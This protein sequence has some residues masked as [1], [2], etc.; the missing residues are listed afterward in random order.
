M[1][2]GISWQ[3]N[4]FFLRQVRPEILSC[5]RPHQPVPVEHLCGVLQQS[6]SAVDLSDT[7]TGKTY[8][9][10]ATAIQL[11]LPTL[12]VCPKI[13][14]Y[15]WSAAATHFNDSFSIINYE[16]LRTGRTPFGYW[17][18]ARDTGISQRETYYVC[19]CCQ[20]EVDVSNWTACPHHPNGVHC[21]VEKKRSKNLGNFV[22][23]S[24]IKCAIFDEAHRC[25]GLD[26]LNAE[27][28]IAARRQ[29]IRTL[30]LSATAACN[31]LNMRAIGY[32]LDL[33]NDKHDFI[34]P[35]GKLQ[36][37][38]R[39]SFKRWAAGYGCRYEPMFRGMK[40]MVGAAT[41]NQMM[42]QIRDRIIPARGVRVRV[43]DIPDFPKRTITAELYDLDESNHIDELYNEM[44]DSLA[45]LNQKSKTDKSATHPLTKLLR[46]RQRLELLKV[47]IAVELAEDYL[48]TGHSV[49]LFVNFRQ[50]L[51]ELQQRLDCDCIIAGDQSAEHRAK[52]IEFFQ[53][54]RARVIIIMVQAGGVSLSL[55]DL[56]G[57]Y[58]RVGLV[59]PDFSAPN[60]RQV[61]GRLHRDGGRSPCFYRVLFVAR[62]V[63]TQIHR[64][65]SA[66]LNNLDALNNADLM[67]EN[68]RLT[69]AVF[70]GTTI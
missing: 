33:H 45:E 47:P 64:S 54:N 42:L 50:T 38:V 37:L 25:G 36:G 57:G 30:M 9:A 10:A 56:V 14:R 24:G 65:L 53:S 27:M 43:E 67:P 20:R 3:T 6:P 34:V 5:L 13:G 29:N 8:V 32:S 70:P 40:W 51:G 46:A 44:A 21:V 35:H 2:S 59:M 26:S 28:L 22:F 31:P 19:Q 63:E 66:K 55:Q 11:R 7:G 60:M 15:A 1:A 52:S 48:A 16:L 39:P 49:A 58:P 18:K 68:L 17:E 61:F 23:H 69:N 62:S 12:I 41:Q 4:R